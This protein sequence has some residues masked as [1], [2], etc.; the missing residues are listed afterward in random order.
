MTPQEHLAE[1]EALLATPKD[2][3]L[4]PGSYMDLGPVWAAIGHAL[5][6]IAV[7]LGAPHTAA[8]AAAPGGGP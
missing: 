6:A 3:Y 7:E 5:V 4:L 8:A 1:A 2:P